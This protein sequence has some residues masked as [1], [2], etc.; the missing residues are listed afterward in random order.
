M[1]KK[2]LIIC[3]SF[4]PNPGVGGRRWAML[5]NYLANENFEIFVLTQKPK[6]NDVSDFD[7]Y[8]ENLRKDNIYYYTYGR[9]N[10]LIKTPKNIIQKILYRI[11]LFY[12]KLICEGWYF[13]PLIL[14]RRGLA[15]VVRK[16][17]A[18]V[19]PEIVITSG[20]PFNLCWIAAKL[21]SEFSKVKFVT[22]FRDPWTWS[23]QIN[24]LTP[25]RFS[26]ESEKEAEC[27]LA[28]DLILVPV[29]P[30]KTILD[31]K[32]KSNH[33]HIVHHGY[34]SKMAVKKKNIRSNSDKL[35]LV[36]A[37]S[38]LNDTNSYFEKIVLAIS[39]KSNIKIDFYTD[40]IKYDI[41][42]KSFN[43]E[44]KNRIPYQELLDKFGEYNFLL[45]VH[46]RYFIDNIST[47]I[48]ETLAQGLPIIYVG[49]A[50]KLST[51]I[52]E[53]N[54]GVH[55]LPDEILE[56]LN[57][58]YLTSISERIKIE[59]DENMDISNIAHKL[60]QLLVQ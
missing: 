5:S 41:L 17:I 19:D 36:Y 25:S 3:H 24:S 52:T 43:I 30:M 22:D 47:K 35:N 4:P 2:V 21:K 1:K 12:V 18:S 60:S 7:R 49:E 20:P 39:K 44:L 54:F 42:E 38:V 37:G 33:V 14:D 8:V 28:S 27:I 50:G 58:D 46:P 34:D 10:F 55:I 51:F 40:N 56:K 59:I 45:I 6:K 16:T 57:F 29:E 13:D 53:N 9:F 23:K 31:E 26:N 15:K 32:Y 48:L 11:S